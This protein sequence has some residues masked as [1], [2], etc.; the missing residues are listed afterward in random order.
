MK[1]FVYSYV[2]TVEVAI[3]IVGYIRTYTF[4]DGH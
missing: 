1:P 4:T 3:N 2:Y